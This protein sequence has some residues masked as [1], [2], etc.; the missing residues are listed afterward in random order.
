MSAVDAG[1]SAKAAEDPGGA[2]PPRL[3]A[4]LPLLGHLLEMRR[5]PLEL[6]QRVHDEC[7]EI[8]EIS[9]AGRRV[10]MLSGPEAH[11]AFFRAPDEQLDQAAA[12]PFMTPIFGRGVV[13]DATP[14][15]RKRTADRIAAQL[16][17]GT[18]L[19]REGI[20]DPRLDR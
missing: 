11:E 7:G 3:S 12:Y 20:V 9:L 17:A 15:Q 5:R 2:T 4:G 10:V 18:A 1:P 6:F 13:F 16:E 14:E 19:R 8:G